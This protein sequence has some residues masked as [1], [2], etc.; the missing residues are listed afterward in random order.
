VYDSRQGGGKLAN[1][2]ERTISVATALSGA[3]VV[4]AGASAAAITLTVTE[5][6]G[7]GGYVAAFPAGSTWGGTSAVNWFGANQNLA[8]ADIVALG[9]NRDIVLRGGA[10]STHVVVDVTAYIA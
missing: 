6:D 5:T 1:G 2:E 4:P 10:A 3:P 7:P 8:T 9:P